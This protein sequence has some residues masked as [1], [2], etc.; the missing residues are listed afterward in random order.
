MT[1]TVNQKVANPY[2]ISSFT[3]DIIVN[4]LTV[5]RGDG[6]VAS[7]TAFGV[8]ALG[9]PYILSTNTNNVGVGYNALNNIGVGVNIFTVNNGGGVINGG[10]DYYDNNGETSYFDFT[11]QLTY[12]SGTASLG[13]YPVATITVQNGVVTGV[14][15]GAGYGFL[16]ATTVM[17]AANPSGPGSGLLIGIGSLKSATNNTALGVN[18][19]STN[20]TGSN[21]VYLGYGATGT[22]SNQIL[23]GAN[24]VSNTDNQ[25]VIGNSETLETIVKGTLIGV[26][27][28]SLTGDTFSNVDLGTYIINGNI[29]IGNLLNSGY[30]VI[31]I[32][33]K[34]IN[35]IKIILRSCE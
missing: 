16:D 32:F 12:V 25:V 9:S 2:Y 18:A 28:V 15:G 14:V 8:D 27:S 1:T 3:S 7:N 26:G 11:A 20:N 6:N 33:F 21:S 29:N 22:G 30:S 34:W 35:C 4:G 19:G 17:T 23:I 24:A 13:T 31:S 10:E 5:G